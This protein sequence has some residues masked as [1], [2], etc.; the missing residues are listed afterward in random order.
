MEN[1]FQATI[2]EAD[3]LRRELFIAL[4]AEAGFDAFEETGETLI[5][6]AP[7]SVAGEETLRAALGENTD[8][9]TALIPPQN[10]NAQW[11]AGFDPVTVDDFCTIRAHFHPKGTTAHDIVITPKMSFGTGHHATTQLMVQAMRNTAF[12]GKRVLDFGSGTGVLAILAGQLGAADIT[13]IDIDDWVTENA[14]E[15]GQQ[16]G[17]A[18]IR[19][20]TGSLEAVAG[21][22]YDVILANINRHILLQYMRDMETALLTGGRLLLSGILTADEPI[23]EA[24]ANEVGLNLV[25]RQD[26]AGWA[27][28]LFEKR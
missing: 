16:N 17:A 10:W 22:R 27:C 4:L 13:G 1:T 19:F 26:R 21:E 20:F 11:E 5:A 8:F 18:S 3:P 25:S 2:R 12:E 6:C 9:S 15:N 14:I 23:I 24:A 28:M 7:E